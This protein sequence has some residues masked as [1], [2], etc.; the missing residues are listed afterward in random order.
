MIQHLKSITNPTPAHP[1]L[2]GLAEGPQA[3]RLSLSS[4]AGPKRKS[5]PSTSS[6]R[7]VV[8]G[9][10][11]VLAVCLMA[12]PST[13]QTT[14]DR[15]ATYRDRVERLEDQNA[16]EVLQST[17]GYYFDKGL[18]SE[19]AG[20]F[21]RDGTFEYGMRGVYRGADRIERALLL[22][23]PEGLAPGYLNNHM[24]LQAVV[25]VADDGRTATGRWQGM[26]MLAQPGHNGVWGVG[27]YENR[28]VKEGG[29]WKIASLH[30]YPTGFTDYDLGW[31]KSQLPLAGQSALFPPD[32]PPSEPYRALPSNYIPP[33]SYRHPVTGEEI[34]LT[35]PADD[36]VGRE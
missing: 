14:E 36:L 5:G 19:V 2:V 12:V 16:I 23:G 29:R 21:A 20:L 28:Y 3:Q 1:E 22:L 6:G 26:V 34:T 7:A 8:G 11:G 9:V 31:M 32:G 25:D 33:F 30:F 18:W 17:Y 10:L 27:I 15:L 35:Q 13:A 4:S 24:Q